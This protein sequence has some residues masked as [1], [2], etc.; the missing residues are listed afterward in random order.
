LLSIGAL[1]V[2]QEGS[3]MCACAYACASVILLYSYYCQNDTFA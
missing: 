2:L 1:C 3:C